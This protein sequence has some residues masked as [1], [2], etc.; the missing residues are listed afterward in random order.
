MKRVGEKR[1]GETLVCLGGD[2][3]EEEERGERGW[4]G[5]GDFIPGGGWS[6]HLGN[7][8]SS[9]STGGAPRWFLLFLAVMGRAEGMDGIMGGHRG[10]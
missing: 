7:W 3:K 5:E 8:G 2:G 4:E 9:A 1:Q 10:V 6:L